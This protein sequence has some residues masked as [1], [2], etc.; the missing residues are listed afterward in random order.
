MGNLEQA[1]QS[2]KPIYTAEITPPKGPGIKKLL[3]LANLLK[4][5]VTAINLTDCQRALVRMSSLAASKV[6]LDN[7][8]EPVYQLTCRDRNSIALQSD[9]MGAAALGIPNILCLT[10]DPVKVGDNPTAKPVFEMESLGQL[11]LLSYLQKGTDKCGH[12][13]NRKTKLHIGAVVN[14]TLKNRS[15][16]QR[17][18]KK[19][20]LGARFFQTQANYDLEDYVAFL[21]EAR[22]LPTKILAGVLILN[23][24]EIADYIHT[25]IPGIQVPANLLNEMKSSKDPLKTG[26]EFAVTT[27]KAVAPYVDGFH[28]MTIRQEELIPPVIETYQKAL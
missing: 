26:L 17:M 16:L 7:G 24:A 9:C 12:K 4:P 11:E 8:I 25:Q 14:P 19:L 3:T 22:K 5:Y 1:L 13:M 18:Q 10:G 15:Q 28:M 27:M 23:S 20:E 2:T 21:Q 6:L